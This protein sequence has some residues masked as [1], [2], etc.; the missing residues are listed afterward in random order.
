MFVLI[1][2][3]FGKKPKL[4]PW[5]PAQPIKEVPDEELMAMFALGRA[6]AF[7]VLLTRHERPII[8]YIM[9]SCGNRAKAEDLTQEVFLR[10]IKSAP[11]YRK[12][13]K[14]TTWLYTIARNISID[15]A[16]RRS[17][18]PEVSL[19]RSIGGKGGDDNDKTFV[20]NVADHRAEAGN[21][22]LVRQDFRESLKLALAELPQEQREVF[23]LREVSG[24]KFREIAD[25][26]GVSENTVKSRMRYALETLRGHLQAFKGYSFDKDEQREM[27]T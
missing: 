26:V 8:G 11:K 12:T 21:V 5:P 23:L 16:R 2:R 14:F 9:R 18:R 10:V 4:P 6:E 17:G 15:A 20:A 27:G 13:A 22:S 25:V 3:L 1:T 7:E 19:D 24:M